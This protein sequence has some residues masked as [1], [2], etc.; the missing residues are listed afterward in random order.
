VNI[1]QLQLP[2]NRIF[3]FFTASVDFRN[4]IQNFKV[5]FLCINIATFFNEV[6][7]PFLYFSDNVSAL[8]RIPSQERAESMWGETV[9]K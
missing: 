4:N 7:M 5:K 1:W 6:R 3:F 9:R 2:A 8:K